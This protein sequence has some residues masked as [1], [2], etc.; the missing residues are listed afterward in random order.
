V[1]SAITSQLALYGSL[2]PCGDTTAC[3]PFQ[4]GVQ[5]KICR[6]KK[7]QSLIEIEKMG[8]MSVGKNSQR[9]GHAKPT[10]LSFTTAETVIYEQSVGL[11]ELSQIEGCFLAGISRKSSVESDGGSGRTSSHSGASAIQLRTIS[12]VPD[13]LNSSAT[14]VGTITRP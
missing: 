6:T 9:T 5:A 4:V 3:E 7:R 2:L 13:L 1:F 11:Q 14:V 10:P 8:R 12:G